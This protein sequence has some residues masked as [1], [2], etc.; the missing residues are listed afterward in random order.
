MENRRVYFDVIARPEY[1][2]QIFR[3]RQGVCARY[4]VS[5]AKVL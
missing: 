2:P 1:M 5:V 3:M 4:N